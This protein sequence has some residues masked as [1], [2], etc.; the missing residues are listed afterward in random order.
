MA[1]YLD[2]QPSTQRASVNTL[3]RAFMHRSLWLNDPDCIMLRT[4]DTRLTPGAVR[5]WANTVAVSGGMALVSDDLALL[6][7][8]ARQLLDEVVTRGKASDAEAI[9][10]PPAR[11]DDL[12]DQAL[13]TRFVAAGYELHTD[14]AEG[15][16]VLRR[17]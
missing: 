8:H 6:D 16:S 14:P 7:A 17:L 9:H 15:D 11:C 12:L 5:T 2:V 1:G 10:W 3:T 13:P 4:N